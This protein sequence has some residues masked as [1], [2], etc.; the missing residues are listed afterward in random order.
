M[1]CRPRPSRF[2]GSMGATNPEAASWPSAGMYGSIQCACHVRTVHKLMICILCLLAK[3]VQTIFLSRA[4]WSSTPVN[5]IAHYCWGG[6]NYWLY[7]LVQ[8]LLRDPFWAISSF[9]TCFIFRTAD[10]SKC[11]NTDS[12]AYGSLKCFGQLWVFWRCI[13][14]V[15]KIQAK[16]VKIGWWILTRKDFAPAKWAIGTAFYHVLVGKFC[17]SHQRA[18]RKTVSHSIVLGQTLLPG[19]RQLVGMCHVWEKIAPSHQS[20][21]ALTEWHY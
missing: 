10:L 18:R 19:T 7:K 21:V 9:S 4:S 14:N 15:V 3:K 11:T 12:N 5:Q 6:S 2:L 16:N 8:C 17:C 1:Q 20:S 13:F